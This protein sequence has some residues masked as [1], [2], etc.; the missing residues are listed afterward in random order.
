MKNF[1][2]EGVSCLFLTQK[3]IRVMRLVLIL[4]TV[5]L[6]R[7][8]ATES[9]AQETRINLKMENSTVKEVLKNIE[10]RSDFTFYY[11]DNVIDTDKRVSVNV[12][13]TSISDILATILPDCSFKVVNRNIIITEKQQAV[14]A[15]V[16]QQSEKTVSGIVLDENGEP[17]IGANVVVKGTAVGTV[18]DV[19]GRFS[20]KVPEGAILT[21]SYIGYIE[22]ELKVG[23]SSTL[24]VTLREDTQALDEV[25]VVAYGT[26]KKMNLTGSVEVV[27]S[28]ELENRPVTS[29]SALLQGQV[30]GMTFS[31]PSG[32]NTPGSNMTLQI[33]GQA[34]LSGSTP[35][36]VVIDGIPSD[37]AAFNALNPNDIESVSV[38][39]DAAA[40]AVYGARAPY[41][42]LV[43]NTKMG[44]KNEKP[45]I[46][47]S[48]NYGVVTPVRVPSMVDSYTFALVRNQ[49][50]LNSRQAVLFT[51]DRIDLILDNINNP[52]KY[53][54]YELNPV[55][56]GKWEDGAAY[57]NDFIDV[58][59]RSSFRHQHDLSVRGGGEKS[60]Y[61]VS[62]A[63][64]YQP[65]NLNFVEDMDNY[66]R[67]NI[68]GNVTVDVADW[69]KMTYRARYSNE[70]TKEPTTE[71][72]AGRSRLYSYA[73]GCWP[74][75]PVYNPDGSLTGY[76]R[77]AVAV[78]GGERKNN[79]HRLDN[80]LAFDFSLAKGLT[81]HVDGTWRMNFQD[82]Q[83][84][85]KPVYGSMPSGDTYLID[86]TE[87]RLDKQ[88]ALN[89]YWTVQAYAAYEKEFSGH[90]FRLQVGGQ[91]E[92]NN[93]RLLSGYG[94]ELFI[95]DL[96]AITIAQGDRIVSDTIN[97]WATAGF[98]GRFNYNYKDRYLLEL[99]GRYDGSG[100]YARGKRWGFFPSGS[101]GWVMSKESFWEPL[102]SVVNFS[103]LRMSYG[104]L[105]NQGNSAGYLHVPTMTVS[106][107]T[108]W[109]FNGE[110]LPYVNT[111]GILNMN[112]TWEKITTFEVGLELGMLDNRLTAEGNYFNRRSWDIIGP[113]TPKAAVLGTSAPQVNNAEFVTNGFE[114]Q[115]SWRDQ[116]TPNWSYSTA[117]SLSD[118]ISKI[119]KYNTATNSIN[120]WYVGKR[121]GEIW[122]YEVNR[123]LTEDDFD[124]N[125]NLL[126]SQDKI[127][128]VW[129]PG[130]LKYEDIDGDG[131]ISPGNS[132]VENP[133]DRRII[134]N[135]TP[136]FRYGIN[137][138]T[139]Y[140]F[141]SA[142]RLGLSLFFEGV[143]KRDLFIDSSYFFWGGPPA[144]WESGKAR[145]VY[146]GQHLDFYRDESS[147]PRLLELLGVNKDS[148][149]PRPYES[150]EGHKNMNT[151]T[152]YLLNAA[153][154]RLKNVTLS[155]TLPKAWL[156][157]L[158]IQNCRVYFSG[159]NLFAVSGLPSYL[160][161]EAVSGGRMYPQT[162]V[163]SF[164]VNVDF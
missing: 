84:L 1:N 106:S 46:S 109:I 35:P 66:R 47:Y 73:Y 113:P 75:F 58:W 32:G 3:N 114:L 163:Y 108:P 21:I 103:K 118:G 52:G 36:L 7:V 11:N 86:G 60:S 155:Y 159:E 164:G 20:L 140:D 5:M 62:A 67:F 83:A 135:S 16:G 127:Y 48:G 87:S 43:V 61:F 8:S 31:T 148:Y 65:G 122:G 22:Q 117:V 145:S 88:M 91:A 59:L 130:D 56:S 112:R 77:T 76:S 14:S 149:F 121:F 39:K 13:N 96:P 63:Y 70:I 29:A 94:K 101:I 51:D 82:Y 107:Q 147:D 74:V 17:V 156:Q 89:Q 153:Y 53:T 125:G 57:N 42:V 154:L 93:Y 26:Q 139:E 81:A 30:A 131:E 68:N 85:Q 143:A 111:P 55:V 142:G 137:L 25:V 133:G 18:T 69:L 161:P 119:T 28:K 141:K 124:E 132:T 72:N 115:L 100:R 54:D 116:I 136:R 104:T 23:T 49:A 95:W 44:K 4:L 45:V 9:L 64:V 50:A 129:H 90:T 158:K 2:G 33:R 162:A 27:G 126:I 110:R 92:E 144:G 37:M 146:K 15:A 24:N 105:G 19:D 80:I 138:A 34:A 160:D 40:T 98:F 152:R 12:E 41:G 78:N 157:N 6:F 99:N 150:S 71:Y 97:D 38:L 120:S 151:N 79:Q 102:E 123:F 10:S 128:S 134:G